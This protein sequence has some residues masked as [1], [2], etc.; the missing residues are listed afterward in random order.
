[1]RAWAPPLAESV[2]TSGPPESPWQ[3]SLPPPVTPAQIMSA[4]VPD[5]PLQPLS[6]RTETLFSHITESPPG[7]EQEQEQEKEKEKEQK[8][9]PEPTVPQPATVAVAPEKVAPR[10]GR[11]AGLTWAMEVRSRGMDSSRT[12][13][14]LAWRMDG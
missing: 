5:T 13:M 10:A 1:M 8:Q 7:Q 4:V 9:V 2:V 12:E 3:L 14:S 6:T 11:Q